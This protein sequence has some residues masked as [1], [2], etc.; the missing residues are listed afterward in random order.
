MTFRENRYLLVREIL[1][2]EILDYLKG[3]YRLLIAKN[4]FTRGDNQCPSSL[5][6]YGDLGLDAMLEWIKP[7]MCRL[8]DLDLVPTY[9]YTRVYSQGEILKP[10]TDR[11]ACEIS[12]T[13]SIRIPPGC[14]RSVLW[15]NPGVPIGIEMQEGDGLI[16]AGCEIEHWREPIPQPGY[17]QLFLHFIRRDGSNFPALAY[18]GRGHFET[19]I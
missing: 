5:R 12:L 9:S 6:L 8:T 14:P 10:H 13:I 7:E 19:L 3:Y 4:R 11:P 16:Y 2:E 1:P 17:I 15:L 18:D